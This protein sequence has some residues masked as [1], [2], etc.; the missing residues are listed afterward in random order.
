V[1]IDPASVETNIVIF[2]VDDAPRV[3]QRLADA[4]AQVTPIGPRRLR[5]VTH[6]DLDRR[7]VYRA[8]AAF[9]AVLGGRAAAGARP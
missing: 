1:G 2:E 7:E 9:R 5:A 6:G 3:A 8:L 4:G